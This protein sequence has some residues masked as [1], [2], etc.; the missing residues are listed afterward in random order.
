MISGRIKYWTAYTSKSLAKCSQNFKP[1]NA[2]K[3]IV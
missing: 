3:A 1:D 2:N